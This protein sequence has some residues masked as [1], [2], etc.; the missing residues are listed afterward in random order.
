MHSHCL[1]THLHSYTKTYQSVLNELPNLISDFIKRHDTN[2]IKS[3]FD[4]ASIEIDNPIPLVSTYLKQIKNVLFHRYKN[5]FGSTIWNVGKINM[6]ISKFVFNENSNV[7]I[8]WLEPSKGQNFQADPFG[9]FQE[10][11]EYI[12]Y[13]FYDSKKKKG[14]IKIKSSI[15]DKLDKIILEKPYHLSYPFLFQ[16]ENEWYCIPEQCQSNQ[17]DL[18][19]LDKSSRKLTFCKTLINEIAAVDPTILFYQDKWWLFCTDSN[20]KGAD[21]RLN[22]YFANNPLD[23]WFPHSLNPVK[24]DISSARP[25]GTPFFYNGKLIRPSQNSSKSYG[26]SIIINEIVK[27]TTTEF[28]EIKLKQL[29]PNIFEGSYPDGIHTISSFGNCTLIDGKRI[30]YK[31]KHFLNRLLR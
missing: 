13:E 7:N 29:N 2:L 3:H 24:T 31:F 16:F 11:E 6:P 19:K 21:L 28:L 22:I 1:K 26:G 15:N 4:D 20:N 10:K 18:Y 17:L 14:N 12:L 23:N 25:A 8:D 27:L 9:I 5:L 30:E